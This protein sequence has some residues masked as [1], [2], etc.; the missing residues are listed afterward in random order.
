[1]IPDLV[2]LCCSLLSL[3]SY[4]LPLP[5]LPPLSGSSL[6]FFLLPL[7]SLPL[8]QIFAENKGE[9]LFCPSPSPS[10]SDL[11]G[12]Q[13]RDC[14]GGAGARGGQLR[15]H[16]P[17]QVSPRCT[18]GRSR[19]QPRQEAHHVHARNTPQAQGA[20]QALCRHSASTGPG[21]G[22]SAGAGHTTG[23]RAHGVPASQAGPQGVDGPREPS[24]VPGA[25]GGRCVAECR[26]AV[27]GLVAGATMGAPVPHLFYICL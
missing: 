12:E 23:G 13:G 10:C 8:A 16:H 9:I 1:M 24:G 14:G 2:P 4:P 22:H 17:H 7:P 19:A 26:R 21:T 20:R 27:P 15:V 18:A 5:S 6:S 25:C 3:S 11:C